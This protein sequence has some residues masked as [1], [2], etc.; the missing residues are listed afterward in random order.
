M[1]ISQQVLCKE[2]MQMFAAARVWRSQ[3]L[4]AADLTLSSVITIR[5]NNTHTHTL[6]LSYIL[7]G[8]TDEVK[9]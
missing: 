7:S 5:M 1:M 2:L 3:S 8:T 9:A 4:G 6:T